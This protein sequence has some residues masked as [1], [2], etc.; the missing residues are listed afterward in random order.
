MRCNDATQCNDALYL[1][2]NRAES[3]TFMCHE[4]AILAGD[5]PM[6]VLIPPGV[7]HA[8]RNVGS[9]AGLVINCPNR[10]YRGEGKQDPVDEI[11][12]EDGKGIGLN[13]KLLQ[14]VS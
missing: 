10:L 14:G 8:H 3:P 4:I 1:W 2:D 11:R 13:V 12:H 5:Q 9:S 7:V 6:M